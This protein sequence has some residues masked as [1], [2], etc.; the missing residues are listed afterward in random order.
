[1]N[2]S[3]ETVASAPQKNNV[4]FSAEH[5]CTTQRIPLMAG[6]RRILWHLH[7]HCLHFRQIY[8]ELLTSELMSGSHLWELSDE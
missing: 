6:E 3:H 7:V 4:Q 8:T 1:M 2:I 5:I